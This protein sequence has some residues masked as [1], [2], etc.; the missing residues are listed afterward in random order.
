M[1]WGDGLIG[2][3]CVGIIVVDEGTTVGCKGRLVKGYGGGDGIVDQ[4][5]METV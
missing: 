1:I 4:K 2:I 5:V 3:F